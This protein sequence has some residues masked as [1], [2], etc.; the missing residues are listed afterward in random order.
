MVNAPKLAGIE[1]FHDEIRQLRARF[2][3]EGQSLLGKLF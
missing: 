1:T 3:R 2:V